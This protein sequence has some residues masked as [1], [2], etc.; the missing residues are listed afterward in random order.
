MKV[1]ILHLFEKYLVICLSFRKM[2]WTNIQK[3]SAV[4]V[5]WPDCAL[6]DDMD[7]LN[8]KKFFENH[9]NINQASITDVGCVTTLPDRTEEGE[10]IPGTGGRRDFFFWLDMDAIPKFIYAKTLLNMIWWSDVYFNQQE[11]MYPQD[12]LDAYP[13]P[14]IP[15]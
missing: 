13:D 2:D 8:L 1:L 4:L 11:G 6:H 7:V 10:A 14:V 9:L 12:F 5:L 15:F 3:G